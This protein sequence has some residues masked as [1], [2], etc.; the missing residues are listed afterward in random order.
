MDVGDLE[1]LVQAL[2]EI[3]QQLLLSG[4]R[5]DHV[6]I[7]ITGGTK[8][9]SAAG[10]AVALAEGRRFQV[11]DTHDHTVTVFDPTYQPRPA[12]V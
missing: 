11:V 6:V 9:V 5:R 12:E 4:V 8:L 1:A 10:V 2:D 7:D 3:Y